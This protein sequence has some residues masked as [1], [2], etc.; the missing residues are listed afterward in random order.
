M[1]SALAAQSDRIFAIMR[2]LV[3]INLTTHG[4]QKLLGWF[5]RDALGPLSPLSPW[6]RQH[7]GSGS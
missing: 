4:T 1:F 2:I 5:G 7:L 3:G 6:S